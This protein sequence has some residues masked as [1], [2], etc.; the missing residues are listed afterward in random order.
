MGIFSHAGRRSSV[1]LAALVL[2]TLR[3]G[4][5]GDGTDPGNPPP[6]APVATVTVTPGTD[7]VLIRATLQLAVVLHDSA[8]G[9]LAGR[10]ITWSV[11]DGSPD[12]TRIAYVGA[13]LYDQSLQP[14]IEAMDADGSNPTPLT[15]FH[16]AAGVPRWRP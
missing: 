14:R 8:G 11:T 1:A 10:P 5:G 7:T 13:H 3:C 6:A 15:D 12:G 9:V 4:G 16:V 2:G